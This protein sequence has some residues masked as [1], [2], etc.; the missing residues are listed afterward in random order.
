LA[1]NAYAS[2]AT[3]DVAQDQRQDAVENY[4]QAL[5]YATTDA[6]RGEFQARLALLYHELGDDGAAGLAGQASLDLLPESDPLRAEV[7]AL[8]SELDAQS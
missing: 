5:Q 2:L 6:R 3:L 1:A 4:Q 7:E 8:L